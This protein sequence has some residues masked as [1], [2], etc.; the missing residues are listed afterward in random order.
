VNTQQLIAWNEFNEQTG[1][2]MKLF[3]FIMYNVGFINAIEL[4]HRY[5]TADCLQ[6]FKFQFVTQSNVTEI[7][8][9]SEKF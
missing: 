6:S 8:P 5:Y 2:V 1:L 4:F 3:E 7:R 9:S